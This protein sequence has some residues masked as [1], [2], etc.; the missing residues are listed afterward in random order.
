MSYQHTQKAPLHLV[1][2]PIVL[3]TVAF[4]WLVPTP[5]PI[6]LL[7]VGLGILFLVL[8]LMFKHLRIEDE[9]DRLAIRYGPLPG[10][11]KLIRYEDISAVEPGRS[12]FA[13]GWG[14]HYVPGRGWTYNLWG[15]DCAKLTVNGKIVRAGTDDL[16]NLVEFLRTRIE[17]QS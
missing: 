4:A 7:M 3:A 10:F 11:R 6:R 12:S 5:P 1:F 14:I 9:G 15:F 13:D 16:A 17:H 8:A 2:Y